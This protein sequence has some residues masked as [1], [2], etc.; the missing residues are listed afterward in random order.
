AYYRAVARIGM[1]VADALAYAHGQRILH[2]DIKPSNIMLD[3][4]G[5]VWVTDFGLAKQEGD[6]LTQTGGF[7]GTLRYIAPERFDGVTDARGDIYGLGLTLYELLTLKP[8]FDGSDRGRLVGNI[9]QSEPARPRQL[10]RDIPRDLETVILKAITKEPR[11]R[12]TS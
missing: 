8:A 9:T 5:A 4:Q 6:D 3:N 1:Q 11:R 10:V 12:Y 7:A 2:R